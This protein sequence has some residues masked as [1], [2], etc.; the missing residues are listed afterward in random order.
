M[1][2]RFSKQ[3]TPLTKCYISLSLSVCS[4]PSLLIYI[5]I[6]NYY[7][8]YIYI[9]ILHL[10]LS[11]HTHIYIY[12]YIYIYGYPAIRAAPRPPSSAAS[13]LVGFAM[14]EGTKGTLG[15]GTVQKIGV[16]YVSFYFKPHFFR[17][18]AKRPCAKQPFGPL[19]I[20]GG[21]HLLGI[22]SPKGRRMATDSSLV[23][24]TPLLTVPFVL[25]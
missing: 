12:I 14:L 5:Y 10:S 8:I 15:K 22:G 21:T 20:F 6:Y 16:H 9:Y 2:T 3:A 7:Y 18:F 1:F 24:L 19:R 4:P 17:P 13:S 23:T 25:A 11:I